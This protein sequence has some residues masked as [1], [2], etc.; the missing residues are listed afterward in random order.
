MNKEEWGKDYEKVKKTNNILFLVIIFFAIIVFLGVY[1]IITSP[2]WCDGYYIS[3]FGEKIK[4]NQ[5]DYNTIISIMN[6]EKDIEITK[7]AYQMPFRHESVYYI[8]YKT[9]DSS[10]ELIFQHVVMNTH[11]DENYLMVKH[12]CD[13]Y[14]K[15]W[16]NLWK[17]I[18]IDYSRIV[19]L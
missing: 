9:N 14:Y 11:T 18:D 4:L 2:L 8:F 15:R 10:E 7:I 17:S 13:K 6:K 19:N 12:I 5:E 16:Q 3:N 1:Y